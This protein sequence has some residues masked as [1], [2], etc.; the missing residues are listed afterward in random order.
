MPARRVPLP[1]VQ[2]KMFMKTTYLHSRKGRVI[3]A[4]ATPITN[5]VSEIYN[6]SRFV[7]PE[8]LKE[9]GLQSF[10]A[11]AS[12]FGSII[13]KIEQSP[14]GSSFR[15]KE[16]FAKFHNVQAMVGLFRQFTDVLKTKDVIENLPKAELITVESPASDIHQKFLD[17]I[18]TRVGNMTRQDK[19]DNML[20]VTNDGR[21]MATDLRLVASQ[22]GKSIKELDVPDSKIN[23][24]VRSV[25]K[26]YKESEA[27]KGTQFIFLD[28]GMS[29]SK[30]DK[31]G[32]W[33]RYGFNLYAD[34]IKKL[35][36]EGIPANEIANI[37]NYKSVTAK[38]ELFRQVNAGEIRVLLGSTARMGEGMN[39]QERAVAIHHLNPPYRPSDIE[40]RN[41]RIV[42]FGNINENIREY[43]Y[44]QV[45]SFDSY[46]WQMLSRKA[47]FV[48][49]AM[50]DGTTNEMEEVDEF[51]LSANE[52]M[53]IAADNPLLM[54]KATLDDKLNTLRARRKNYERDQ[55]TAQST[56]EKAPV[57]IKKHETYIKNVEAD[58]KTIES[59]PFKQDGFEMTVLGKKYTKQKEAGAA[60]LEATKDDKYQYN[61][62]YSIGK[63]RGMTVDIKMLAPSFG[64]I[65]LSGAESYGNYLS[66]SDVGN[67]QKLINETGRIPGYITEAKREIEQE[68]INLNDAK[69]TLTKPFADRAEYDAT[70]NRL[71]QIDTELNLAGKK[72]E[73]IIDS[74]S[75]K[76]DFKSEEEE[77]AEE[78]EA[79][80]V[81]VTDDSAD[82]TA[83]TDTAPTETPRFE[84]GGYYPHYSA[85]G[86]TLRTDDKYFSDLVANLATPRGISVVIDDDIDGDGE[87]MYSADSDS[88]LYGGC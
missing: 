80:E 58:I 88:E 86:D 11:W 18:K 52:L 82:G 62:K 5:S 28:F 41:G 57:E 31:N 36:A 7:A 81:E 65:Y 24:C 61:T 68:R 1:V 9:A 50:S 12:T 72:Q 63:L 20:L 69:E 46:M 53:A 17:N 85:T 59:N 43:R 49:Q 70:R 78:E 60:I 83:T 56:I 25:Y 38:I 35:I 30:P 10:D 45:R 19:T 64:Y 34:L 13:T 14:D 84:A 23:N 3:F 40:Q 16:R 29:D 42:R 87:V 74:D 76:D 54:E 71:N 77:I 73:A 67:V 39:A 32:K 6:M 47:E 55:W 15:T 66:D 37:A 75:M 48:N 26:E 44:V 27:I 22:I 51:V 21:A 79:T 8:V 4:T 2:K 33:P